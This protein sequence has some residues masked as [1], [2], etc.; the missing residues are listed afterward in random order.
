VDS[1]RDSLLSRRCGKSI[2]L[3]SLKKKLDSDGFLEKAIG[4]RHPLVTTLEPAEAF[5][6]DEWVA[7]YQ[8]LERSFWSL[9]GDNPCGERFCCGFG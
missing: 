3:Y 1:R 4:Q 8:G 5:A 2:F 9:A 7:A 6:F